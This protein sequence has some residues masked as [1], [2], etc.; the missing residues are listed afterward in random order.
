MNLNELYYRRVIGA[1]GGSLLF[2]LLFLNVFGVLAVFFEEILLFFS[3][4]QSMGTV[5]YQLFYAAGY[6]LSFMM[7]VL[8][9][10]A[11]LKRNG[12]AYLPMRAEMKLTPWIVLIVPAGISLVYSMAYINGAFVSIFDYS[13]FSSDVLWGSVSDERPEL[14]HWVLEFITLCLVPG[15]CEEFFFRGAILTNCLP[16]GRTNAILISSFLFAMMHQNAEQ[17]LYTFVAGI[18]LGLIYERT[19]NLWACTVMHVLNNFVSIYQGVLGYQFETLFS[20]KAAV[21]A[22]EVVLLLVGLISLAILIVRFFSQRPRFGD[23]FF[24]RS[25]EAADGYAQYPIERRRAVKLFLTPCM[26]IFLVACVLQILL[27]LLLAV[28]YGML[29]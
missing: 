2:F 20:A 29:A 3:V 11:L 22:A 5:I 9:L 12:I 28:A 7:P 19:G 23:G 18:V 14:Y 17:V 13:K 10:K 8:I 24:G 16:F 25:L 1:I 27:L 26:V 4:T 15:F 6:L 21:V